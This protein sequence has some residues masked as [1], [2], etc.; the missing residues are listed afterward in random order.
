[1]RKL[2][3]AIVYFTAFSSSIFAAVKDLPNLGMISQL[4]EIKYSSEAYL[5]HVLEDGSISDEEK[6]TALRNYNEV[7]IQIDRIIYQLSA[8]MR[9]NN[10]I[11][12]YKRLNK[13]YR[14]HKFSDSVDV[15]KCYENYAYALAKA[16]GTYKEK[17][18]PDKKSFIEIDS[19]LALAEFGWTI[20]KDIHEMR[21]NKVDGIVEILNNLRLNPPSGVGKK[22]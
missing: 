7:R 2:F 1:M 11:K 22:E 3:L 9:T 13:Y 14:S 19:V 15:K 4:V 21:G 16:Y 20:I 8:D 12:T 18:N 17:I 5:S 10:S 6:L